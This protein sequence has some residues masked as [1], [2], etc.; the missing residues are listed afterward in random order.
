MNTQV[1]TTRLWHLLHV[2]CASTV[3]IACTM[4]QI[5]SLFPSF[6]LLLLVHYHKATVTPVS[7]ATH[8]ASAVALSA[9]T[10]P[11]AFVAVMVPGHRNLVS[12]STQTAFPRNRI[13]LAEP[14]IPTIKP[15]FQPFLHLTKKKKKHRLPFKSFSP[16]SNYR[17]I[18][19]YADKAK[20]E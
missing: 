19:E 1:I 12:L 8:L 16:F 14:T 17:G 9:T 13:D 18:K 11:L 7:K 6:L 2:V 20:E 15:F 10:T 3:E 4:S 5:S